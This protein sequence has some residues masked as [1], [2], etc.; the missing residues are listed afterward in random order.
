MS[1][2]IVNVQSIP[3][4]YV[5]GT[6]MCMFQYVPGTSILFSS[7]GAKVSRKK[8]NIHTGTILFLLYTT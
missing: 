1:T 5:K 6:A 4:V 3:T 7:I 8:V 2:C